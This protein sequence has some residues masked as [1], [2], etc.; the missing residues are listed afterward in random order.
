MVQEFRP[1]QAVQLEYTYNFGNVKQDSEGRE[2]EF[3]IRAER[4][5][6]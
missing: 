2:T 3:L 5:A 1:A 4:G 6:G